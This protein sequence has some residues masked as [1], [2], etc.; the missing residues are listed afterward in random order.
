MDIYIYFFFEIKVIKKTIRRSLKLSIQQTCKIHRDF[1]KATARIKAI[2]DGSFFVHTWKHSYVHQEG[3]FHCSACAWLRVASAKGRRDSKLTGQPVH[4]KS[5]PSCS[6]LRRV[7]FPCK[8]I[9]PTPTLREPWLGLIFP[10]V[11]KRF[12]DLANEDAPWSRRNLRSIKL[13]IFHVSFSS[14][15]NA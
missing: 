8:W 14:K 1:F 9:A 3:S 12:C 7:Q 15:M 4:L 6:R 10:K 2:R 5:I 13:P 11:S